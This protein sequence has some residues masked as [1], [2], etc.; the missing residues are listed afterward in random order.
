MSW[1]S[2]RLGRKAQAAA[3]DR[4]Y[5]AIVAQARQPA[6]YGEGQVPDSLDGRFELVALHTFLA[7]RRLR[8][9]GETG[10]R[11]AQF[12]FDRM[13]VDMDESLREIGVGDLGVGRRVKTMAKAFYGR[14]EAY[15][16]GLA[17]PA[18][19]PLEQALA[20]NLYGTLAGRQGLPLAAVARYLRRAA[21]E[22]EAQA[23]PA[24]LEGRISFPPPLLES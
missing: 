10:T 9:E 5:A 6:F 19:E 1:F 13:F 8:A 11:L 16:A 12:L 21:M 4:L 18:T 3:A 15:E 20:R 2:R 24:L 14:A 7:L 17:D 22:I 23:G